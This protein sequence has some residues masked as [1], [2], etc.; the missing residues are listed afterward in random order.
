MPQRS[1]VLPAS[2]AEVIRSVLAPFAE[3]IDRVAV[4]GSHATGQARDSSDIDLVIY[5][6][7]SAAEVDRLWT[8][9]DE[10]SLAVPVDL[11]AYNLAP[12]PPL[13]RRIDAMAKVLF[14]HEDLIVPTPESTP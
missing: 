2:R 11:V 7:L 6:R 12:Y 14:E 10:S 4:F 3:K 5:G 1:A 13:K 8:L 9:F